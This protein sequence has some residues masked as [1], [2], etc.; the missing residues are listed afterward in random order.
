MG[1]SGRNH[2]QQELDMQTILR[3]FG[4]KVAGTPAASVVLQPHV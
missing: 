3:R 1:Q 4:E 2:A